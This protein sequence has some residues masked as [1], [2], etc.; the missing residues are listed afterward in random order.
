MK[1]ILSIADTIKIIGV[2]KFCELQNKRHLKFVSY[3]LS[4]LNNNVLWQG[5]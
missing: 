5:L 3:N 1:K 4:L 2:A